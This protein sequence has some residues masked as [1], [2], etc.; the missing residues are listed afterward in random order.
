MATIIPNPQK[1]DW[2]TEAACTVTAIVL[3][4]V[5]QCMGLMILAALGMLLNLVELN[6]LIHPA[7][8]LGLIANLVVSF[9]LGGKLARRIF[10]ESR[11]AR[12][13]G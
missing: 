10:P 3:F 6:V 13:P 12:K 1:L 5:L 7:F 2:Q 9:L 8:G 4:C 11:R